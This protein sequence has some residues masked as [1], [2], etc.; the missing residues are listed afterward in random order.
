M[1]RAESVRSKG[2]GLRGGISVALSLPIE[3][4]RDVILALMYSVVIFL[5][6]G[7][8]RTIGPVIQCRVEV[9]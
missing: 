6:P 4:E 3:A 1:G 7:Q 9:R 5:M 2:C 8:G